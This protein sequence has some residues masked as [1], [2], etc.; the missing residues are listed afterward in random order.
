[1][2]AITNTPVRAKNARH[3]GRKM[4][5]R[6]EVRFCSMLMLSLP[7]CSM[8]ISRLSHADTENFAATTSIQQND[9]LTT[10]LSYPQADTQLGE[11]LYPQ[12]ALY[13]QNIADELKNVIRQRDGHA[14]A[15]RDVHPKAHGCVKAEF[16]VLDQLPATLAQGL[17][18]AGNRYPA[19]IRFSNGSQNPDHPDIK[20]DARGMA[21]KV[22]NVDGQKLLEDN[23]NPSAQ[24]FILI[25][26]PVF[27]VNDPKRY[28]SLTRAINGNLLNKLMIPFA[29]GFKGSK[30]AI[31]STRSK[32]ANPVQTRYWSMTAYQWGTGVTRNA[33]K[34]SV[35]PCSA[36]QDAIPAHPAPNYL[37]NALKQSLS[38]DDV[39]MEFLV[40]PRTS[41]ALS[42]ED[43]MTEWK[44]SNAPFYKVATLTIPRQEFD[45]PAQNQ[46]CEN[47]AFSPWHAL[48]A[49]KPLGVTNRLR[50]VVYAQISQFRQQLNHV[51]AP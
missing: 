42:V 38:K 29:L 49:H 14:I 24:D 12:E 28:L 4:P 6:T 15:R 9:A 10:S 25:N 11:Q 51:A 47:L 1:M 22:L 41:S 35:R 13:A 23:A 8:A 5:V 26:H 27:F 44:E 43:A 50:K 32:I 7:L 40:Q 46:F 3:R 20:G 33:V 45:N 39:C 17:F 16:Q 34:Y 18:K 36:R 21:I 19:W 48:P 37:R 31:Q 30:I 2:Q